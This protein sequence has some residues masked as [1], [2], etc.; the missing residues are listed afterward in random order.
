[1]VS[2]PYERVPT[3]PNATAHDSGDDASETGGQRS[4][5]RELQRMLHAD[6]RFNR[7]APATWKRVALIIGMLL[8]FW[9]GITMRRA[10]F[11]PL[12]NQPQ[13]IHAQRYV[14]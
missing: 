1:M 8:L 3:S 10:L 9:L 14:G 6:P 4:D 5:V 11:A 12:F 2:A 13:V 7:P